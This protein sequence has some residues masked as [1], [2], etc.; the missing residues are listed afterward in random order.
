M[1][2]QAFLET[3]KRFCSPPDGRWLDT[4]NSHPRRDLRM[5]CIAA[6]TQ[7]DVFA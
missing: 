7:A 5:N 6:L 1:D 2:A 4:D 3:P